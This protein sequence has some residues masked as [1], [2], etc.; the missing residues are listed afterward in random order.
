MAYSLQV[1][2]IEQPGGLFIVF[3]LHFFEFPPKLPIPHQIN[4]GVKS[5]PNLLPLLLSDK[6]E[7]QSGLFWLQ[8]ARNFEKYF[9]V[10]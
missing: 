10:V 7:L 6:H 3:W 4:F 9:W 5:L 1:E 2:G 8:K